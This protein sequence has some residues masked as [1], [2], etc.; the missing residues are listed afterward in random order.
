M[1]LGYGF[2]CVILLDYSPAGPAVYNS[3]ESPAIP[4]IKIVNRL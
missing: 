3:L 1:S 4:G 2:L